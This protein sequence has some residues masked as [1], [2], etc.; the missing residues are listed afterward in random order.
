ML[1]A[2]NTAQPT[3]DPA[4][5]ASA[6]ASSN[7]LST[8]A[9][10][11]IVMGS[12]T[13]AL[14]LIIAAYLFR[15]RQRRQKANERG[16]ELAEMHETQ[17]SEPRVMPKPPSEPPGYLSAGVSPQ[18]PAHELADTGGPAEADA[19]APPVELAGHHAG[20]ELAATESAYFNLSTQQE[21]SE[22]MKR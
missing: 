16:P 2:N 17:V 9:I 1:S 10:V 18:E 6:S 7:K 21:V 11:G 13:M 12:T 5:S 19:G 14:V 3:C 15:Q 22:R 8:G 4:S 20:A